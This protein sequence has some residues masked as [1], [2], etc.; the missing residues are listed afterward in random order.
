M[1]YAYAGRIVGWECSTSKQARFV[2][3]ALT[4][5]ATLEAEVD[6]CIAAHA[7]HAD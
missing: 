6:A 2:E 1:I 3:S 5:D 4:Q 7:A